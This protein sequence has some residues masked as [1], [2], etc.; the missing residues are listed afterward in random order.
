MG[1]LTWP[2]IVTVCSV[3]VSFLVMAM[4][5]VGPDIVFTVLLSW[6]VVFKYRILTIAQASAGYGNSGLL[7]VIMLYLVAEGVTQTGG[8]ELI[9]N[10]VLG[11]SRSVHWALVRSMLP[12][13]F[14]S[15]FLNN[16]PCVTFMIPILL[17]W[18]RRCG[19]PPKK[20]L[21]PLSY[22]A[23]LGGTCTSIGTSTN[24]VIVGLQD[25]RY[26]K[27]KKL[28]DVKFK[29]FDIA[30]YG[31]PYA[32]WG[33]IFVVLT[34]RF[35]LPGN[36]SRYAKDLLIAVRVLSNSPVNKK[37]I[38]DSGLR[39]QN[40]FTITALY[41]DGLLLKKVDAETVLLTDDIL[42]V[43]GE[44]DVV[45]FVAE[46]FALGLVKQDQEPGEAGTPP[47]LSNANSESSGFEG[48]HAAPYRKLIQA[49]VSKD[50]DLIGHT[51][52]DVQWVG[53]YGLVPF[54]VQ[55]GNGREDG[56]LSDVV[57]AQNDVLVLD[58]TE[59]FNEERE[60]VKNN[61][62]K[63]RYVKD[64]AAKEFIIGVKVRKMS[65]VVNKTVSAAGLRGIPGL[66]VL[67]VDRSDGTSVESSDYLYKIQP[68][69]TIWIAADIAAV[70][71]LSKFPG[72]S[73]VQQEQVDKTGTSILFRHLV[74]AAVSHKGALVGK[75]VRDVRFR[76]IYNA[77]VVAVHRE[78]MRVPLKVQDIVLQGGDVLLIS[79][80][81]KWTET[82]R[83]D[84]AFV[85]IQAVPNSSPP[86]TSRM[87]I[88]VLLV[89]GMVLTQIIGG[90]K[91]KEYV[92]LWPAAV[93]TAAL[94][95]LT[96]CMNCDQARRAIMWDVYL[97]IAA[98]FG[99]SA[100]L[101][102]TGVAAKVANGIIRIG[103][104]LGSNGSALVAIYVATAIMSEL[105]TNNAAG[106]IMYPIAS[107]AGDTLKIKP[108]DVSVAIMLGASAGFINPFSYQTN[109]MVYTAGNYSVREFAI[110][111]APFQCYLMV[112]AGFI[113][114]YR[115]NWQ[116][117]WI[118]AWIAVAIFVTVPGLYLLLPPRIQDPIEDFF[119]RVAARFSPKAA[120]Q[121]R[122]SRAYSRSSSQGPALPKTDSGRDITT[123]PKVGPDIVFTVLLSWL[124]VF[125]YKILTIAQASA[126]YGNSGLLTVIMLYLVAEG[127]TQTGGL[128]LIMNYVLG[129]SRSVHW[130]LVRSMLPV[131]FLSAFL[132]NTPC[133]TFMIPILLSWARRCGVPPKKL[134]IPLSYAAVLG[135][136]CTSIG[137]STNLVIVG[138]QDVRYTKTKALLDVKFKMFDIAPYG[139]PYALWGFIFVVITQRFLLPGNSSRYAKDLLLAVRVLPNSPVVKKKL[140]DSG[141]RNQTGFAI[142]A[143]Y[144]DGLLIKKVDAETILLAD[145]ILYV[146]GELD[147]VEFVGEEYALG[148]V[149]Q[150]GRLW[151][152]AETG[153]AVVPGYVHRSGGWDGASGQGE[154]VEGANC[155]RQA[156][157][158]GDSE[159]S[160]FHENTASPYRKLIQVTV[161]SS[162]DLVGHTVRDV[163]WAGRFGVIPI[164]IQRGNGREDGR[165]SDV[166]I[167]SSDVFILDTTEHFTEGRDEVKANFA[168]VRYIK[169][170]AAKEFIIGVKVRRL[171]EVVN[172]TVS[173]AGLRGI[174][175]LF[176]LSVDRAD[177]T[178]VDASDYLY[179]IQPDD[180]IWIAADIAAVGFLSKFP[181]LALV[182]QEQI[183]KTGTSVLFRHLVQAAVSHKGA[184]AGKTV[185]DARFRT[186]YNAAVVAVHRE[187]VRV[188]LKVQDIVL[189]G[190]DVLLISCHSNWTESHRNDKA[191]VLVQAVPDSSPPK[192]SRMIIGVLLVTGMV[193]TQIIGG[194]KNKE[195]V[196]LWPASVI[197]AALML[198]TGCM[199]CDQARRAIMWDVYLTIA[200]AFGVSAALDNT[201]VA[202][203]VANGIIKIGRSVG[204]DGAALVAIY[205]AT[206][207]M[208]ELLTNNAA[209]AIMYP[210]AAIAGDTLKIKPKEISVA[211]ML[212]AS[213]G[214]INPFSYQTNLMVYAAG[215][216]SVR[217]FAIIGAPFQCYLMV[218]AGFILCYRNNWQALWISAWI[219]V[220]IFVTVPGLYLLLPPRIQ[221]P[222]E[223]FFDRLSNSMNPKAALQRR[224]S[225]AYSRSSSTAP[226]L[227]HADNGREVIAVK[228]SS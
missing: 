105:L 9:M 51:V 27:A 78:G 161:A 76:T 85:L 152:G 173:A 184:L 194:I 49:E 4:D 10:Y 83:N 215:N 96:G 208:S 178:S 88:G 56:R 153:A 132:N 77:A 33:F 177:G 13:M 93:I 183:D 28:D 225:R 222:I 16:T 139:V 220:A 86:K 3:S 91:N 98:A 94:M 216:Y 69:D 87:I 130:A 19:V 190:G 79:C 70:G 35:L 114:C 218:V 172:K 120:L 112:V 44:L 102:N 60:E 157:S 149:K 131:M 203:K 204:S 146:A 119:A 17:S 158:N 201:G 62:G 68:D 104:D 209:G 160:A 8:L 66:Y 206:A 37:P 136:T 20:L 155:E 137:T 142:T 115:D 134:L 18:A 135:G 133:V 217:E 166:V 5:W 80:H 40:G 42:Y 113:L 84:K 46:E 223:S 228:L 221:D 214:F 1:A 63:I 30:P 165:L 227:A 174:P 143:L 74:Q 145:D 14:L 169:D 48:T 53:R 138:L 127:V 58:T 140:K 125:K 170:G 92:H 121:R 31:V 191:F 100:A 188:P 38:K 198:I 118:S 196:H 182:Q 52:R 73:L 212:G 6:L 24:L 95:L 45:E 65:D 36:S 156:L 213:A 179:K 129:R 150:V 168:K 189:Q 97:T 154:C 211:I 200:A 126:G 101:D 2:G 41:R 187:G 147:V 12:V 164:S 141:L 111:G 128:E 167:A 163:P 171:S 176:V 54:A 185:R 124:V 29:M 21:I 159:A 199:N 67:S 59:A 82:H 61:L 43:A 108:K 193:L 144:R 57:I 207:V 15:A 50:S 116:A 55:R 117:L 202:A 151:A 34:Q 99:V 47:A 109:L 23:V 25:T 226:A 110:I 192:T 89:T 219:A 210:I 123:V 81:D 11:R 195:Y 186:I 148:L 180:T 32:L 90:L 106:A 197:T 64:G 181:G 71:F 175:G 224:R 75:T 107:I 122:R 162:S 7:T 72:L 26:T 22:A 205:I 103:S 39:N